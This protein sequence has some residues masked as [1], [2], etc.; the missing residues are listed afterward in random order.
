MNDKFI[1]TTVSSS[2]RAPLAESPR[3]EVASSAQPRAT[4]HAPTARTA[5]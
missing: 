1:V 2:A 5:R 4:S 3:N